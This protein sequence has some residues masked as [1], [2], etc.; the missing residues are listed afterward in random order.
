MNSG[1]SKR[2][3]VFWLIAFLFFCVAVSFFASKYSYEHQLI[4]K[5]L[6]ESVKFLLSCILLLVYCPTLLVIHNYAKKEQALKIKRRSL[7][8]FVT[9]AIAALG[10][11]VTVIFA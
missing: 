2:L 8:F 5:D 7:F 4:E 11:I 6:P 3:F 1:R 9:I 10:T